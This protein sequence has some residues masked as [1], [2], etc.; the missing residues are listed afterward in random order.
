MRTPDPND[1]R[2]QQVT[3]AEYGQE[4]ADSYAPL[5][6]GVLKESIFEELNESEVDQL[7]KLLKRVR[8]S[9]TGLLEVAHT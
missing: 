3:L 8:D 7:V 1:R 5:M 4:L 2:A 6:I 9:A